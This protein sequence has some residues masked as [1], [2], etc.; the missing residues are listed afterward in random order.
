MGRLISRHRSDT[1][2]NGNF[3]TRFYEAIYECD[4]CQGTGEVFDE[5]EGIM[6]TC[7]EC[8]GHGQITC[9]E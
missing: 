2:D 4:F 8:E 9:Y 3:L 7:Q 6:K 5:E 1:W